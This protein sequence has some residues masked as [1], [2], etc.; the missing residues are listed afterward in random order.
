MKRFDEE[1]A[2]AKAAGAQVVKGVELTGNQVR[3]NKEV[4]GDKE[5]KMAAV[6]A[7]KGLVEDASAQAAATRRP[8]C[9]RTKVKM[10]CTIFSWT[11]FATLATLA[12]LL[13]RTQSAVA[14]RHGL[15]AMVRR[16]TSR[17][18]SKATQTTACC[19]A[20]AADQGA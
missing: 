17:M 13:G 14:M 7:G 19:S 2:A 16:Q 4:M 18:G 20:R 12:R 5:V 3:G 8:S 9:R 15:A 6:N 1:M 10:A 11:R